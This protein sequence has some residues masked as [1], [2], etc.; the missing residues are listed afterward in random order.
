VLLHGLGDDSGG[1]ANFAGELRGR[2]F[3]PVAVDLR[4]HGA[5]SSGPWTWST[6]NLDLATV[7]GRLGLL[8]PVVAGHSLGG[9]VASVWVA[10]HPECPF[11]VNIDGYPHLSRLIA[12]DLNTSADQHDVSV[13]EPLRYLATALSEMF[14]AYSTVTAQWEVLDLLGL[15]ARTTRPVLIVLCDLPDFSGLTPQI[16]AALTI[17]RA[18]CAT[19]FAA[20]ADANANVRVVGVPKG[21]YPHNEIPGQLADIVLSCSIT[22]GT[23]LRRVLADRRARASRPGLVGHPGT[24]ALPRLSF[25]TG[26]HQMSSNFGHRVPIPLPTVAR[27]VVSRTD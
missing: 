6:V 9:L 8:D 5:F 23:A 14:G 2:G 25:R 7:I 24:A 3:R 13:V 20:L 19:E 21:H 26:G 22:V 4:G 11:A 27:I 16:V 12:T 17:H 15:Y 10:E 18:V 1:W